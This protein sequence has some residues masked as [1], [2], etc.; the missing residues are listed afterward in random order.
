MEI[1]ALEYSEAQQCFHFNTDTARQHENTNSYRTIA[2]DVSHDWAVGFTK[3][4]SR[5]M[6]MHVTLAKVKSD[7]SLFIQKN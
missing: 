4:V 6:S 1:K 2:K 3:F 5:T 7:Y